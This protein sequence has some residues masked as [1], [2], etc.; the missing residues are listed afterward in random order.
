MFSYLFLQAAHL[1][2]YAACVSTYWESYAFLGGFFRGCGFGALF[3]AATLRE[4][5]VTIDV[6]VGWLNWEI[7]DFFDIWPEKSSF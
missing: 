2:Y 1:Y 7:I 3:F 4:V 5:N 6:R